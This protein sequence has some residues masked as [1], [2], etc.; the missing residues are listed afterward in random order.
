MAIEAPVDENWAAI[1]TSVKAIN[2]LKG[3]DFIEGLP[4][5]GSQAIVSKG[6]S[7]GDLGVYI[8][9]LTQVSDEF[10]K[11]NNL[12]REKE[13]ND[14]P[15]ETGYLE[16]NRR[17]RA[18]KLGGHQSDAMFLPLKSLAF[19]GFDITQL[20]E[21]D[22]F[23]HLN[24]VEILRKFE[25]KAPKDPNAVRV[26]QATKKFKR[27]DAKFLPE[28]FKTLKLKE[29]KNLIEDDDE[30]VVSIKLHGTSIRIGNTIVKRRPTWLE[31][32]AAKLGVA[33]RKYDYDNVYGSRR[34][35]KDINDPDQQHFYK[36]DIWTL[37]GRKLDGLLPQG[38]VVYGELIGWTPSG[39][40]IQPSYTYDVPKGEARLYVYRVAQ[41]NPQGVV[42]DLSWDQMEEFARN[43][44]LKTVPVVY[45]GRAGDFDESAYMNIRYAD[46]GIPG[47]LP[48][49]DPK[50]PDEG[51]CIRRDGLVPIVLKA[52]SPAFLNH[53]SV[54]QDEEVVD[55]E[56][57]A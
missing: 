4:L 50:L 22:K 54:L 42:T 2:H 47:A 56:A 40:E 34:V 15:T 13:L 20:K 8:P 21:G 51:V 49:S 38:F 28:N 17:V 5:F 30:I 23:D 26:A 53:E 7:V 18:L 37:E 36:E 35:I 44:G 14:D 16:K 33:V 9:A 39:E 32:L 6:W 25:V 24:G 57:A 41:V 1:V 27:A 46:K 55:I 19:T 10:A 12:Y 29:N 31:R 48:L 45:K 3:R 11:A 43:L 52:K